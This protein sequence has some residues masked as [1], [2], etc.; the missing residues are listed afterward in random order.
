MSKIKIPFD[1]S[2][3]NKKIAGAFNKKPEDIKPAEGKPDPSRRTTTEIHKEREKRRALMEELKNTQTS[4][5]RKQEIIDG[6]QAQVETLTNEKTSLES[7]VEELTPKAKSWSN[8]ENKE[9]AKLLANLPPERKDKAKK[10]MDSMDLDTAREYATSISG[11]APGSEGSDKGKGGTKTDWDALSKDPVALEKA[12]TE[13]PEEF[14]EY[15]ASVVA[16]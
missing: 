3:I 9:R 7:K 1:V 14:K 16:S 15:M 12:M 11:K 13:K 4:D 10:V 5:A 2:D 8:F 6:L